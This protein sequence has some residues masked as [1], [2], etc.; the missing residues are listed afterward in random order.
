MD[1]YEIIFYKILQFQPSDRLLTQE[2]PRD[3]LYAILL[4]T[5]ALYIILNIFSTTFAAGHS[6]IKHL[7]T[8]GALG[9][10]IINGWYPTIAHMFVPIFIIAL[11]LGTVKVFKRMILSKETETGLLKLGA[12]GAGK[13]GGWFYKK[14]KKYDRKFLEQLV[15]ETLR[16]ENEIDAIDAVIAK[17]REREGEVKDWGIAM[18]NELMRRREKIEEKLDKNY[19]LR[20]ELGISDEDLEAVKNE[21]M[22]RYKSIIKQ[23]IKRELENI[24]GNA[25]GNKGKKIVQTTLHEF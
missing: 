3:L 10:I 22:E 13:V 7:I 11:I 18:I 16:L 19:Q 9:V 25:S 24:A 20:V 12:K 4:P 5:I 23:D 2:L 6:K 17:L 14:Y 1:I 21:V 8:I 15:I